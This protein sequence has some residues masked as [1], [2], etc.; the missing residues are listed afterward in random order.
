M[1]NLK[2]GQIIIV[3]NEKRTIVDL[4]QNKNGRPL[5]YWESQHG[6]GVCM[7]STWKEWATNNTDPYAV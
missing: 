5:I 3:N 1:E 6:E 7:I 4:K 2:V